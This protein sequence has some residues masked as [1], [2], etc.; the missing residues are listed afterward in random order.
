MNSRIGAIYLLIAAA[1]VA[2]VP[3]ASLAGEQTSAG[4]EPTS[5]NDDEPEE[6]P[7]RKKKALAKERA[8]ESSSFRLGLVYTH[9]FGENGNLARPGPPANAIGVDLGF[10]LHP[11]IRYH[12]A[13]AHQWEGEGGYSARGFLLDLIALGFPIPLLQKEVELHL[14]PM[15]RIVRGEILFP[16]D[17]SDHRTIFRIESGVAVQLTVAYRGWFLAFQPVALDFRY[18]A[19]TTAEVRTGFASLFS[20][21]V[22]I[23]Y[24]F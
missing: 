22:V 7:S 20:L 5:E 3:R 1:L 13:I 17:G 6:K 19:A 21:Q 10:G 4:D 16:G 23:G 12:L 11:N 14:E 9:L 18:F 15:L 8:D 24:G 2:A